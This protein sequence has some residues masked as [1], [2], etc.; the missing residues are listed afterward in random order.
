MFILTGIIYRMSFHLKLTWHP[1]T[2]SK[3]SLEPFDFQRALSS[4][5]EKNVSEHN[6]P[7]I[8]AI[9]HDLQH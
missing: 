6:R 9:K 2:I 5:A 3:I 4:R 7:T 1:Q 8:R